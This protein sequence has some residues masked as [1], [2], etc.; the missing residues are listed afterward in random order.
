MNMQFNTKMPAPP[1]KRCF[2]SINWPITTDILVAIPVIRYFAYNT[3]RLAM[4]QDAPSHH[5]VLASTSCR[6]GFTDIPHSQKEQVLGCRLR[7]V[8]RNNAGRW[9]P[10]SHH[11]TG[12]IPHHHR[13]PQ[14]R[15]AQFSSC[16]PRPRCIQL[17]AAN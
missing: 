14:R 15:Y 4:D 5:R 13:C 3:G 7:E 11:D 2:I 10:A 12:C 17:C 1:Q 8:P 16:A 6:T 9:S